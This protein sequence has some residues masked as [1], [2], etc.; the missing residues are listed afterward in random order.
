M[1]SPYILVGYPYPDKTGR[2]NGRMLLGRAQKL[3]HLA[4]HMSVQR[5]GVDSDLLESERIFVRILQASEF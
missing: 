3:G 4:V 2:H 5:A 1:R